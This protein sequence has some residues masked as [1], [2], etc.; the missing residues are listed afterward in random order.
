MKSSFR[1]GGNRKRSTGTQPE[2]KIP[3]H[4]NRIS[5]STLRA[6]RELERSGCEKF[7]CTRPA[8]RRL[9][10]PHN[11]NRNL[12][13]NPLWGNG[14]RLRLRL[15]L[16]WERWGQ[17]IRPTT[18][19]RDIDTSPWIPEVGQVVPICFPGHP[20]VLKDRMSVLPVS[21]IHSIHSCKS[22]RRGI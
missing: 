1:L 11:R 16:R 21:Q 19:E 3:P 6:L 17:D 9:S 14:L 20:T 5:L 15:R 8:R 4:L 18:G 22:T 13:R 2:Y 10:S 7:F 12:N